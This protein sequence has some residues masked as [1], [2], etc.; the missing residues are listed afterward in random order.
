MAFDNS[1]IW[2]VGEVVTAVLM[3]THI[4][5]NLAWLNGQGVGQTQLNIESTLSLFT[6]LDSFYSNQDATIRLRRPKAS[7]GG[8][9]LNL[10]NK[11]STVQTGDRVVWRF[12]I[13]E[14][15][16]DTREILGRLIWEKTGSNTSTLEFQPVSGGVRTQFAI[17]IDDNNKVGINTGTPSTE[18]EINGTINATDYL[19]LD[20][21][22]VNN[23]GTAEFSGGITSLEGEF[24]TSLVTGPALVVAS[25]TECG[26]N[27][28][29]LA[30]FSWK[31]SL[32]DSPTKRR[33]DFFATNGTVI[34]KS[35]VLDRK[36]TWMIHWSGQVGQF[37][38]GANVGAQ[39]DFFFTGPGIGTQISRIDITDQFEVKPYSVAALLS[40]VTGSETVDLKCTGT[41]FSSSER[42]LGWF[43]VKWIGA[44]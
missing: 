12:D 32:L 33:T 7:L 11:L 14:E 10:K 8:D 27:A 26:A 4:R 37:F 5:D 20:I 23:S 25:T 16:G 38:S 24:T 6:A 29:L 15:D 22:W 41:G 3:N 1:H 19:N 40:S 30:D 28:A 43:Q 31:E 2:T 44:A 36:G 35:F 34:A 17:F 13:S 39:V 18:L 9:T 42:I 21:L